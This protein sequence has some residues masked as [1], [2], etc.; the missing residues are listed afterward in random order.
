MNIAINDAMDLRLRKRVV[1][2][3]GALTLVDTLFSDYANVSGFEFSNESVYANKKGTKAIRFDK[4]REGQVSFDF[5]VFELKMLALMLGATT[6]K[7][8]V[9]IS[10]VETGVVPTGAT[11]KIT[12]KHTPIADSVVAY[13]VNADKR[14]HKSE[15]PLATTVAT[16]EVTF[17]GATEGANVIVY[18]LTQSGEG[19]M[20][21]TIKSDEF[22]G[23]YNIIGVSATKDQ[24]DTLKPVQL[25]VY[26]AQPVGNISLSMGDNVST[27][28]VTFDMFPNEDNELATIVDIIDPIA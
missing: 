11:K 7:G 10:K 17:T 26:N 2:A 19:S 28:S 4:A 27:L 12:L 25:E 3:N 8:A 5:E 9:P 18:Y 21:Y 6:K 23:S 15:T 22:A 14:S 24:F 20:S 13:E 16:N 1:S